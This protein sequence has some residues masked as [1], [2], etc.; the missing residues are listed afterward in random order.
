MKCK[1]C[2]ANFSARELNC[3]YCGTPNPKGKRWADQMDRA[4]REYRAA[5][6][7]V[8]KELPL[9][10][11]YRVAGRV[12]TILAAVLGLIVLAV[13][14][15]ALISD[16]GGRLRNKAQRE[17]LETQM[18][19]LYS[20]ERFG[21]LYRLMGNREL[22]GGDYYAYSQMCLIH[23]DYSEF[24]QG[25]MELL[26]GSVREEYLDS[27][28]EQLL[29]QAARLLALDISAYPDLAPENQ[30]V[31]DRYCLDVTTFLRAML[32]MTEEEVLSLSGQG[33]V[34]AAAGTDTVRP[35]TESDYEWGR[36]AY[37]YSDS[38]LVAKVVAEE[39]WK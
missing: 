33:Y 20:Q 22:F 15:W 9:Q 5:R 10:V 6:E 37:F 26:Q 19:E 31:Y 4:E 18:A 25:R 30:A 13:V 14:L 2:G 28:I 38:P 12:R 29:S 24:C 27:A 17:Q 34:P 11:A 39:A 1:N 7:Q 16:Y 35:I 8:T 36:R 21:E 32:G 23:R 3:P